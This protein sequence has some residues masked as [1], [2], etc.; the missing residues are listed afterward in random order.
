MT[1]TE[2]TVTP[3]WVNLDKLIDPELRDRALHLAHKIDKAHAK[4]DD[5]IAE[6]MNLAVTIEAHVAKVSGEYDAGSIPSDKSLRE[7]ISGLAGW[8]Q[9]N[10][11]LGSLSDA[12]DIEGRLQSNRHFAEL[13]QELTVHQTHPDLPRSPRWLNLRSIVTDTDRAR[14]VELAE[15]LTADPNAALGAEILAEA[16]DLYRRIDTAT[17][18]AMREIP[19]PGPLATGPKEAVAFDD[20]FHHVMDVLT[21]ASVLFNALKKVAEQLD[22]DE[23]SAEVLRGRRATAST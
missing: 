12:T 4:L 20:G 9:L 3:D 15:Q 7:V 8:T 19:V 2:H 1:I 18:N 5:T 6:A 13:E 16:R 11:A 14:A 17:S 23:I 10:A 21:G 22:P